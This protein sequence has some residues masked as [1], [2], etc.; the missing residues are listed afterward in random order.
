MKNNTVYSGGRYSVKKEVYIITAGSK[1]RSRFLYNRN[2]NLRTE[3]RWTY[4]FLTIIPNRGFSPHTCLQCLFILQ[5]FTVTKTFFLLNKFQH[6]NALRFIKTRF[7]EGG[8][9]ENDWISQISD[10]NPLSGIQQ[11]CSTFYCKAFQ[12]EK[13]RPTPY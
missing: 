12:E 7:A 8:V 10:L 4:F 13:R 9:E 1:H 5:L 11:R 3:M 2:N 6:D